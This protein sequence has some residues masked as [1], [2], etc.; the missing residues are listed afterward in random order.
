MTHEQI[1]SPTSMNETVLP[2]WV[3]SDG[4]VISKAFEV[5]RGEDTRT[6][7][8]VNGMGTDLQWPS[9]VAMIVLVIVKKFLLEEEVQAKK[10]EVVP[11]IRES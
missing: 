9:S 2:C 1:E 11:K 6:L 3:I 7:R 5:K 4:A 10:Q 8:M